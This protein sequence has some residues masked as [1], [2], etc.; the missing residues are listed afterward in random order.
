MTDSP[1]LAYLN[2]IVEWVCAMEMAAAEGMMDECY[3]PLALQQ[4]EDS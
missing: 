2:Y 1:V 4:V 3:D